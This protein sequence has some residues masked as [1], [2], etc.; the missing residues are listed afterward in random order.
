MSSGSRNLRNLEPK[1]YKI[2]SDPDMTPAERLAEQFRDEDQ[3]DQ[4]ETY[5]SGGE[6]S[7]N[8]EEDLFEVF[9]SKPKKQKKPKKGPPPSKQTKQ[10]K[11]PF[12]AAGSGL[13]LKSK[14]NPKDPGCSLLPGPSE[15]RTSSTREVSPSTREVSPSTREVSPS[16]REVSP[17]TREVSPSTREVSPG[18]NWDRLL[19]PSSCR[20]SNSPDSPLRKKSS[21]VRKSPRNHR[22]PTLTFSP[23]SNTLRGL[24]PT[25]PPTTSTPAQDGVQKK[26]RKRSAKE[27]QESGD[28]CIIVRE[29]VKKMKDSKQP[30]KSIG[31]KKIYDGLLEN[32]QIK[33]VGWSPAAV[34][35]K[36]RN[37]KLKVSHE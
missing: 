17:S 27:L 25:P 11:P 35:D 22:G 13:A 1:D 21:I 9:S 12:K 2:P 24:T 14:Q 5:P 20:D 32:G 10:F 33:A 31:M 23:R 18:L 8:D 7:E 28:W 15:A 36:A 6:D 37:T 4:E 3:E 16:T 29:V 26:T 30:L 19:N 34:K